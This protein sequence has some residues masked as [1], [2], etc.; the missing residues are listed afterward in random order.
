[1]AISISP[2]HVITIPQS[3]LTFLSGTLWQLD[4]NWFRLQL[5]DWEDSEQG[6]VHPKTHNHNTAITIAGVTYARAIEILA[7]YTIQ[8]E[9]LGHPGYTVLLT[10][11]NNNIFAE[12]IVV[13]NHNSILGQNSA[14]LIQVTSGSGLSTEEHDKLMGVENPP[15]QDL[16][17]YKADV[18]GLATE[19]NATSNKDAV[20]AE[21]N[22]NEAKLDGIILTLSTL[23]DDITDSQV[24][25]ETIEKLT[26]NKVT[27]TGDVITIYEANGSTIWRRYNLAN[28]GRVLV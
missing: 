25:I 8:F 1:M 21:V 9:D 11:S 27:K 3:D 23:G 24:M 2:T 10:G 16:D 22:A 7:P 13:T 28:G 4:T 5:K 14:G 12:G 15:S 6:I 19:V 26:G 17:D 20:I 18:S